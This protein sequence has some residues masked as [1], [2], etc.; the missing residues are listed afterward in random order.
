[1]KRLIALVAMI[2]VA[3]ATWKDKYD[4]LMDKMETAIENI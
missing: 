1:M 3:N 4:E 2:C